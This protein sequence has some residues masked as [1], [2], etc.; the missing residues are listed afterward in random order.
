[1]RS[2]LYT[3]NERCK[4]LYSR[5]TAIT[6]GGN[7]CCVLYQWCRFFFFFPRAMAHAT[8]VIWLAATRFD[9]K[10]GE[11][12]RGRFDKSLTYGMLPM[13]S[14]IWSNIY[15]RLPRMLQHG[16]ATCTSDWMGD[17]DGDGDDDGQAVLWCCCRRI[18]GGKPG[19][20][21][22]TYSENQI[23]LVVSSIDLV[24]CYCWC[25]KRSYNVAGVCTF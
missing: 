12:L 5:L 18:S 2:V 25:K 23:L 6:V 17:D 1:M 16:L 9:V 13:T 15:H 11:L 8:C 3:Q 24:G 22:V 14:V 10:D 19:N 7:S 20:G 4:E 21:P